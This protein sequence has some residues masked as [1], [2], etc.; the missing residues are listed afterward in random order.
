[1]LKEKESHLIETL[2]AVRGT[3]Q[4]HV[5]LAPY[6]WFRVGGPAEV[7]F[8]PADAHDLA[9][10]LKAIA[11]R[12]I[13]LTVLGVGSNSLVRDGGIDG[14]VIRLGRAFGEIE[15]DP[16]THT[17]HTG[18][19]VLDAQLA[20]QAARHGVAGLE[21]LRGIPGTLGGALTMNAGAYGAEL[22]DVLIEAEAVTLTGEMVRYSPEQ[23][24]MSYR[25]SAPP[26]PVIFTGA[27]LQGFADAPEAIQAR[28]ADIMAARE[29]SQPVRERTGG[30]TFKNP[31]PAESQGRKAWQL[32]DEAGCRGL[33]IGGAMVSTHHCNFLINTGT[34]TADDLEQLGEEVRRRVADKFGVTLHWEIRRLGHKSSRQAREAGR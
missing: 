19:A 26:E 12:D 5:A 33:R 6:T 27:R 1:M 18:T 34:A 30:S 17:V 28:M 31:D 23:M 25:K 3:L 20:E 10:F 4:A 11:G 7:L 14:V 29:D 24:R 21:F 13:P 22:K 2:P 8:R 9:D 15:V 16:E 32:V